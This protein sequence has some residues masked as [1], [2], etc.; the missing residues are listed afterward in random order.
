MWQHVFNE[1]YL[2]SRQQRL[3]LISFLY[4]RLYLTGISVERKIWHLTPVSSTCNFIYVNTPLHAWALQ[5]KHYNSLKVPDTRA[6]CLLR[7]ISELSGFR[8]PSVRRGQ[9]GEEDAARRCVR[10]PRTPQ[11][12]Q[13]SNT[14]QTGALIIGT[15]S[16]DGSISLSMS[17][18]VLSIDLCASGERRPLQSHRRIQMSPNKCAVKV[19]NSAW[20]VSVSS[21]TQ[22]HSFP[23]G[24]HGLDRRPSNQHPVAC[25]YPGKVS[26][27]THIRHPRPKVT[28][29]DRSGSAEEEEYLRTNKRNIETKYRLH[30]R[31]SVR[32]G[33]GDALMSLSL[34][35]LRQTLQFET[36]WVEEFQEGA[37]CLRE[38]LPCERE[39]NMQPIRWTSHLKGPFEKLM[40]LR[41]F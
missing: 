10:I 26:L 23:T 12:H 30:E 35:L 38:V 21:H 22:N 36:K 29:V 16:I 40:S 19:N 33:D 18:C 32:N 3:C 1:P 7:V 11:D 4:S 9:Q 20:R 6:L 15:T 39:R 31:F 25:L 41:S 17:H 37:E 24:F 2:L 27:H 28:G 8:L 14:P 5:Y 13:T 34:S